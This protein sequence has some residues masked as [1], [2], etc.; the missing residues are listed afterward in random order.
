MDVVLMWRRRCDGRGGGR[1][2]SRNPAVFC[3]IGDHIEGFGRLG[4]VL[5]FK[6]FHLIIRKRRKRIRF[7]GL[8]K[9]KGAINNIFIEKAHG[10][11]ASLTS[12]A[13]NPT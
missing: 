2:G 10:L 1:S 6:G 4:T 7:Y 9:L 3:F 12:H 8:P 13:L 5:I 11:F